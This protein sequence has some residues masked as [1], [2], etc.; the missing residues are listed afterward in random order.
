MTQRNFCSKLILSDR[1]VQILCSVPRLRM[2]VYRTWSYH[3]YPWLSLMFWTTALF[4][5]ELCS[6]AKHGTQVLDCEIL[7]NM[8]S[9]PAS[10]VSSQMRRNSSE[11]RCCTPESHTTCSR[12]RECTYYCSLYTARRSYCLPRSTFVQRN[13]I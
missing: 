9:V 6:S 3:H 5:R 4:Q 7:M 1:I 13:N 2:P 10:V 8:T 12:L 11:Q